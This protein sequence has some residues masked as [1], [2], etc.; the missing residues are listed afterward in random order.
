MYIWRRLHDRR[1][2]PL[3]GYIR[4][5][6]LVDPCLLSPYRKNGNI[7]IFLYHNTGANRLD[8]VSQLNLLAITSVQSSFTADAASGR[9][10]PVLASF[11]PA[12]RTLRSQTGEACHFGRSCS[13]GA[14]YAYGFSQENILVNDSNEAEI[15]DFGLARALD[16]T[17][18]GFTSTGGSGG[19]GTVPYASPEALNGGV[20]NGSTSTDIYSFASVLVHVRPPVVFPLVKWLIDTGQ[21]LSDKVPFSAL[22]K[23]KATQRICE[24]DV[25]QRGDHDMGGFIG[26]VAAVNEL[27]VLLGICWSLAPVERPDIDYVVDVVSL[28]LPS[29]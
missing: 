9:R 12:H 16:G 8:L 27:W 14:Q 3:L 23:F 15:C 22:S 20:D 10:D 25:P 6:E 24:G 29:P 7:K 2:T 21:V 11:Q 5:T 4:G 28:C 1:I 17:R 13:R 18:S 19:I 26:S